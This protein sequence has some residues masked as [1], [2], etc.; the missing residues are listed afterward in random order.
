VDIETHKP[1]KQGERGLIFAHGASVFS[2]YLNSDNNPF[3]EVNGK[4]WYNTAD[5][6]YFTKEGSLILA[7]RLKRFVKIGGEMISL[8]AMEDALSQKWP[9]NEEGPT[10]A[11]H[12]NEIEGKRPVFHLFCSVK[13]ETEEANSA[14][15]ESG[16]SNLARINEIKQLDEIPKLGT[17]KTDYQ[18]L[19][20]LI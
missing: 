7:G 20:K 17:G 1:L 19:K 14:L 6:G 10:L 13:I 18:S 3:I 9:P 12:A 4:Q 16:F 2:G 5:L 15:K 11:I 8:P